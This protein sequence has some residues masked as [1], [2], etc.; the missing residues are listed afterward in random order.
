MTILDDTVLHLCAV[1]KGYRFVHC[2]DVE[3]L[4]FVS[5]RLSGLCD[6][7]D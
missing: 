4:C 5:F 3:V 2:F 7:V 6:S 1:L